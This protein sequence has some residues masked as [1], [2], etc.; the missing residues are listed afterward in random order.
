MSRLSAEAGE[1]PLRENPRRASCRVPAGRPRRRVAPLLD[2][3][4]GSGTL[5][6]EVVL[7]PACARPARVLGF[8]WRGHDAALWSR[9]EEAARASVKAG[10]RGC[11]APTGMPRCRARPAIVQRAGVADWCSGAACRCAPASG[12]R[13]H[14]C[15]SVWRA[16]GDDAA[17]PRIA[18]WPSCASICRLAG[19]DPLGCPAHARAAAARVLPA[20]AVERSDECRLLRIDLGAAGAARGTWSCLRAPDHCSPH[21][22]R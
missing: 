7:T 8:G 5:V 22:G 14:R 20:C 1:A 19:G 21:R 13:A 15:Q 4:C 16:P 12:R 17:A 2:P 18:N 10:V 6:I 9:M 3:L 11:A